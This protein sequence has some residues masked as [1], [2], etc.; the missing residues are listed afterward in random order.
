MALSAYTF[1]TL[2]PFAGAAGIPSGTVIIEGGTLRWLGTATECPASA[3][4]LGGVAYP[5]FIDS[6]VHFTAT[7]LDILALNA[8]EFARLAD[9]LEAVHE[10]DKKSEGVVRV[11]GFDTDVFLEQRLPTLAELDK[12]CPKNRL[13][14]NHIESHA[15]L[16]NSQ[17]LQALGMPPGDSFLVGQAN[18]QARNYFLAQVSAAEREAFLAAAAAQAVSRGVTTIHAMEGGNL[19]H[20]DDV[21]TLLAKQDSLPVST[22]IYPQV[23]A[24][25]WVKELGLR[26]IGGCLPLDG[27]SGV[28]TAALTKPYYNRKDAG[29]LYHSGAEIKTMV[30]QAQKQGLQ[31]AM[32]AC[33]DA[34]IDLFLDG[35]AAA[36]KDNPGLRHRLEHFELPRFDQVQRCKELN[37]ILSMQ[38]AFDYFWGGPEGDYAYTMGPT[39][40]QNANPVGWAV[41]AGLLV[42]G[43]SDSGV[44]PLDPL[45]GIHAALNHH[46]PEQQVTLVQALA[47][48]TENGAAAAQLGDRGRLAVGQRGDIVVLNQDL[49]SLAPGRVRDAQVVAT[50]NG[51]KLVFISRQ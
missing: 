39:G 6:H 32:H 21:I 29:L 47:M 46:S 1:D 42:A 5:G 48:F 33:G 40:W 14:V 50:I 20:N 7:G 25:D 19:F 35:V 18:A 23:L 15:T 44:T 10:L 3:K 8:G 2:Y 17:S 45:L 34:A 13:W 37:V 49:H 24:V 4:Y 38:P 16:V 26:Q 12:A 30:E 51:G 28:Y 31:V 9:F 27:S 41:K 11:W 36:E 43:G 22:V